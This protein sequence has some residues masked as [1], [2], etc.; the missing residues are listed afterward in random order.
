MRRNVSARRDETVAQ[1]AVVGGF[2]FWKNLVFLCVC[3]EISVLFYFCSVSSY[4]FFVVGRTRRKPVLRC[5]CWEVQRCFIFIAFLCA[6]FGV[7]KIR[8]NFLFLYACWEIRYNIIASIICPTVVVEQ[9]IIMRQLRKN[10]Y[11]YLDTS[12][13]LTKRCYICHVFL[14]CVRPVISETRRTVPVFWAYA[15]YCSVGWSL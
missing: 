10:Y 6:S 4:Y 3:A 15:G 11:P 13:K 7:G 12:P 8:R 1:K 9:N 14:S 5:S 2:G